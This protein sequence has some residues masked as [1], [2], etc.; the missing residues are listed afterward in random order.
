MKIPRNA[1]CVWRGR[2]IKYSFV[3]CLK[4]LLTP[5]LQS[6][7]I[8]NWF[9][10]TG[11]MDKKD[12]QMLYKSHYLVFH[13]NEKGVPEMLTWLFSLSWQSARKFFKSV[14]SLRKT[15][16]SF[17]QPI[18]TWVMP[19][20]ASEL[21]WKNEKHM[22][23][24]GVH[25]VLHCSCTNHVQKFFSASAYVILKAS[26]WWSQLYWIVQY[27]FWAQWDHRNVVWSL[28]CLWILLIN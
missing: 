15:S 21:T 8:K 2:W 10:F 20:R 18:S 3:Q 26:S 13:A 4:T 27:N 16:A 23:E 9:S 12:K 19:L 22:L 6:C 11:N 28:H 1:T 24:G 5:M 7:P 14:K 25:T 17:S